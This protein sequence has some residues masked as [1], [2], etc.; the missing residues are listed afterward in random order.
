MDL[1]RKDNGDADGDH[2]EHEPPEWAELSFADP[3]EENLDRF[4]RPPRTDDG[5]VYVPA[6]VLQ[7]IKE[8][9][10]GETADEDDLD[11]AL[12]F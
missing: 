9:S 2:C 3:S 8:L 11:D 12:S 5:D 7:G 6:G 4:D 1:E 10:E